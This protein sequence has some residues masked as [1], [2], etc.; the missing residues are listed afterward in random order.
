MPINLLTFNEVLKIVESSFLEKAGKCSV[1]R[2][3]KK[4]YKR[5]FYKKVNYVEAKTVTDLKTYVQTDNKKTILVSTYVINLFSLI[6]IL[7]K[8]PFE[9]QIF[10]M[11]YKENRPNTRN[12]LTTPLF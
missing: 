11:T 12:H 1:Y 5:Y 9:H 7:E 6:K 2:V 10:Y 3:N 8:A 4:K